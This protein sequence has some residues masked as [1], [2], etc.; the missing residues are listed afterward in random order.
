MSRAMTDKEI[1][2]LFAEFEHMTVW[3]RFKRYNLNFLCY[4]FNE[5]RPEFLWDSPRWGAIAYDLHR[6]FCLNFLIDN[7][8][9]RRVTRDGL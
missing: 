1:D 7:L 9:M 3:Q 8:K 5:Q 4:M 2:E 6:R